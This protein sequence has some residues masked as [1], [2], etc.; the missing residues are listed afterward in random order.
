MNAISA[1]GDQAKKQGAGKRRMG[2][3]PFSALDAVGDV[4]TYGALKYAP[5]GWRSVDNATERYRDAL[6]RHLSAYMQGE[7]LDPESKLRHLA[8]VATNALFLLELDK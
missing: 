7:E 2:L 3:L 6:L 8:H 4:L 1:I 5:H